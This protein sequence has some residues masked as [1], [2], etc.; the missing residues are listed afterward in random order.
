MVQRS[1][2]YLSQ[3]PARAAIS[4]FFFDRTVKH[5]LGRGRQVLASYE[6][7]G[8]SVE[9]VSANQRPGNHPVFT[10]GP[11]NTNLVQ[12]FDFLL[13]NFLS[14]FSKAKSSKLKR[15]VDMT[16]PGMNGPSIR[17]SP[18]CMERQINRNSNI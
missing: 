12:D 8:Y 9:N 14:S 13:R 7:S 5:K 17:T 16:S 18:K 15:F 3:S 4:V 10:I 1:R 6:V 2:K 11:K